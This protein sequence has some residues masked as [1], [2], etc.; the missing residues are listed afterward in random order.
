MRTGK[1]VKQSHDRPPVYDQRRVAANLQL[2][3]CTADTIRE[4]LFR[5]P[6]REGALAARINK[7]LIGRISVQFIIIAI[8]KIPEAALPERFDHTVFFPGK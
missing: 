1:P 6:A 8:L 3:K 4:I 5:L 2:C 7:P